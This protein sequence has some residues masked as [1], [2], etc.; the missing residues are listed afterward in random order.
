ASQK[1]RPP[2]DL[3][4]QSRQRVL[5]E[6]VTMVKKPTK[7]RPGLKNVMKTGLKAR[8]KNLHQVKRLMA[9]I[10]Q[11]TAAAAAAQEDPAVH[12]G[13]AMKIKIPTKMKVRSLI[14]EE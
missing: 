2:R 9:T 10:M 11:V 7:D 13:M 8:L 3:I 4:M 12:Q 6:A 5:Q 1:K 14:V